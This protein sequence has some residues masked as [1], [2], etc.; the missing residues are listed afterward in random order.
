MKALAGK[1]VSQKALLEAVKARIEKYG[2]E[3]K[4]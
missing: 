1:D 3:V 4:P 2:L